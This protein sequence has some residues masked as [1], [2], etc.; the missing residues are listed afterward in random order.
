MSDGSIEV[1][2]SKQRRKGDSCFAEILLRPFKAIDDG[3]DL[4][5]RAS[6]SPRLVDG[7]Q[8]RAAGGGDVLEQNDAR[9]RFE[10]PIDA[11]VG[12]VPRGFLANKTSVQRL[13]PPAPQAQCGD[14][15]DRA[16]FGAAEP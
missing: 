11:L 8:R 12:A 14:A 4:Q 3:D 9:Y 7:P 2:P 5:Y 10:Q 6:I 13:L 15:R 1:P 16:G